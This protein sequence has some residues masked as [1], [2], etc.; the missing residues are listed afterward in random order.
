MLTNYLGC[1]WLPYLSS[2]L[3][4]RV[5]QGRA[6]VC[7]SVCVTVAPGLGQP[8]L[9]WVSHMHRKTPKA[10]SWWE[11]YRGILFIIFTF[12]SFF[13]EF[14]F[15]NFFKNLFLTNQ[16]KSKPRAYMFNSNSFVPFTEVIEAHYEQMRM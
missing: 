9:L 1:Y 7:L 12:F 4:F 6:S 15:K 11:N 14:Y 13:N 3:D 2:Q 16:H 5:L 10:I 8:A